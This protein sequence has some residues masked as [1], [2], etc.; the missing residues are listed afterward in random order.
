MFVGYEDAEDTEVYEDELYHEESSSEQSVDSEVEFHLYSQIHYSQNL[1][2]ISTLEM[3]EEADVAGVTGHSSVL[4]EKQYEDKKITEFIDRG[5]Q[6][7]DDPEIIVLSDT[8]DEDSVY[9]SKVKKSTS[10]LAHSKIHIHPGSFTPNHAETAGRD[11]LYAAGSGT[12]I[13]RQRKS[14]V[15]KLNPVSSAGA[16][17]IQDVLVIDDS[18]EE[19]SLI[20]ESDNVESWMLLGGGADDRDEGIMLNLEG[21]ATPVSEG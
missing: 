10:S 11:T 18:S 13:S 2:E 8:P 14:H 19:E 7:S 17:S 12:D 4:T 16:C 1:G 21:C 5:A 20:S 15:G 3:D 9:K 6:L